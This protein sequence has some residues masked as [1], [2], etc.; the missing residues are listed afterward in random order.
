MARGCCLWVVTSPPISHIHKPNYLVDGPV[1]KQT[2]LF[3]L[4]AN[5]T[6]NPVLAGEH[7][8]IKINFNVATGDISAN[9]PKHEDEDV[10]WEPYQEQPAIIPRCTTVYIICRQTPWCIPIENRTGVTIKDVFSAL[11][12]FHSTEYITEDEWS[13]LS[14]RTQDK[15]KR[16]AKQ[17]SNL[18][19]Y[20]EIGFCP[21]AMCPLKDG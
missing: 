13:A 4:G 6:I 7:P 11:Y 20:I 15:I 2:D 5:L 8:D 12:Q 21:F 9:H 1:L 14:A 3:L 10:A 19:A 18:F 17:V 16:L